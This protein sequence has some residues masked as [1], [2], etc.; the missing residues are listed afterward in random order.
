MTSRQKVVVFDKFLGLNTKQDPMELTASR[1]R[2]DLVVAQDIDITDENK[3]RRR[4]GYIPHRAVANRKIWANK[5]LFLSVEGTNLV[6]INTVASP[7]YYADGKVTGKF[8]IAGTH[9]DWAVEEPAGKPSLSNASGSLYAGNYE[10]AVT[11]IHSD[12]RESS[13]VSSERVV[14]SS[15]GIA[16]TNIPVPVDASIATVRLYRTEANGEQ[17]RFVKEVSAGTTSATLT[18]RTVGAPLVTQ[19]KSPPPVSKYI[20]YSSSRLT[21][22]VDNYLYL[23]DPYSYH[24]FDLRTGYLVFPEDINMVVATDHGV[25]VSAGAMFFVDLNAELSPFRRVSDYPAITGTE[26]FINGSLIGQGQSDGI[27]AGWLAED[28]IFVGNANGDVRNLTDDSIDIGASV[29]GAAIARRTNGISQIITSM[30]QPQRQNVYVSDVDA[31]TVKKRSILEDFNVVDA[32]TREAIVD[33][34]GEPLIYQ[35]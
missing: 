3:V 2:V 16:V 21:V 26:F 35:E 18:S 9:T 13:T 19:F 23:S 4:K 24:L 5:N 8:D 22:A 6:K 27:S 17:L 14:V 29:G 31:P 7:V 20:A 30:R 28:G 33:I 11:Y 25:Y 32:E 10:V 12:G 1:K 34:D 15:G